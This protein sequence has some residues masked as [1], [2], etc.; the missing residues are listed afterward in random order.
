VLLNGSAAPCVFS[1]AKKSEVLKGRRAGPG[2]GDEAGADAGGTRGEEEAGIEGD[3]CA[4]EDAECTE[5]DVDAL[6]AGEAVPPDAVDIVD[7]NE[8]VDTVDIDLRLILLVRDVRLPNE[9]ADANDGP[10]PDGERDGE[11]IERGGSS[12]L[13]YRCSGARSAVVRAEKCS[14]RASAASASVEWRKIKIGIPSVSRAKRTTYGN[15]CF[16]SHKH[17]R[18]S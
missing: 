3:A 13:R 15:V 12:V 10:Y 14:R 2:M 5:D 11:S 18:S 6:S 1:E 4:E 7:A 8:T 9:P 16:H 17:P